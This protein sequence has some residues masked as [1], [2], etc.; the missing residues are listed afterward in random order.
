MVLEVDERQL[1]NTPKVMQGSRRRGGRFMY[2]IQP[3]GY[4]HPAESHEGERSRYIAKGWTELRKYG[5]FLWLE[6]AVPRPLDH[7]FLRGGA[8]ELPWEQVV[9]EGWAY[10]DYVA[11]PCG[12]EID[13]RPCCPDQR[14]VKV[15]FPQLIARPA[16]PLKECPYCPRQLPEYGNALQNHIEGGHI[17]EV[18]AYSTAKMVTDIVQREQGIKP[19][20][21]KSVADYLCGRCGESFIGHMPLARHVKKEHRN[22]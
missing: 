18:G 3:N 9:E 16:P 7:L 11:Q 5:V 12:Y 8:K 2:Y 15:E 19:E 4:I 21:P 22:A 10:L 20:P 17:K 13:G 14:P 6:W 1:T